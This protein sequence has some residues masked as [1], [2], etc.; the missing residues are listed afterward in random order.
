MS[1]ESKIDRLLQAVD[2]IN[3]KFDRIDQKILQLEEKV[4]ERQNFLTVEIDNKASSDELNQ[5]K[6][7]IQDLE[8]KL[9]LTEETKTKE[10]A[11][12]DAYSKRLNILVHGISESSNAWET[13]EETLNV[14]NKFMAEGLCLDPSSIKIIDIHGLPQRPI[15]KNGVKTTRPIIIK[16]NTIFD[17]RLVFA[18]AKHLKSYNANQEN[19]SKVYITEHLPATF[20]KQRKQLLPNFKEAKQ[21]KKKTTWRIL[22]DD[23]CLFVDGVKVNPN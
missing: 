2:D 23:Y 18:S 8:R 15:F 1:L 22:N 10:Q 9:E 19:D 21:L 7:K 3:A 17:K 5:L 4:K 16:V 6:V 13:N 20:L 12:K 11:S 14:F